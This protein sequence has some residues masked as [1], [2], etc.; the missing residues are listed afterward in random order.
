MDAPARP[1]SPSDPSS[2]LVVVVHGM[3][4]TPVSMLSVAVSL[5][6]AGY[7]VLNAGYSS[8]GPSVA[9]IGAGLGARI[10]LEVARRP[11]AQVHFVGHSL[12]NIAVRWLLAHAPPPHVGRVVM[13]APPNQGSAAADR[14]AGSV[15]WLLRPIAELRT[16]GG[17]AV[18]LPPPP[19]GVQVAV[20]AGARDAKVS[21]HESALPGAD[22]H[23]VVDAG[24]TFIMMRRDVLGAVRRFLAT[25]DLG[26]EADG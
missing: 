26:L 5:R 1:D 3:G 17:T 9:E 11:A 20:I 4:R 24:H 18:G 21:V 14:L 7:R 19:P 12:G 6:R 8:Y 13:L 22:A 23:A 15:G 2:Q 10:A 25:G 16:T